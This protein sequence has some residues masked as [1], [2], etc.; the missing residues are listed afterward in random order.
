[1]KSHIEINSAHSCELLEREKDEVRGVLEGELQTMQEQHHTELAQLEERLRMG[2]LRA[3]HEA[4][5]LEHEASH[6]EQIQAVKQQCEDS[7][8]ELRQAHERELQTLDKRLKEAEVT[9]SGQIQELTEE[10]TTLNHR[11]KTEEDQR[12]EL[13]ERNQKDSLYLE[14][15]VESLNVVLDIKNKQLHQQDHKLMQMDTPIMGELRASHEAVMLEHEASHSE[16]IQAVKQQCEDSL[17]ELRQ[18]HERELQT[19]DKRLK[20]AE[21]TLSGQ[22]QELTEE[23]TTLNHRIKTEEDQRRELAERNQKDSLYLEQEVESLNVV[24]DIKNKQLHQQDHKLMQM[25]TP[26]MEKSVKAGRMPS[27][28]SSRRMRI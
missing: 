6:S 3:S 1:M 4:V 14:Q 17:E 15:E 24:L 12:R 5:M 16:Q 13:A 22:I 9:L 2:E 18:A 21:V 19:L 26:I 8:E 23:N 27:K 7:L 28:W 25:D 10:N 11:I 20:E